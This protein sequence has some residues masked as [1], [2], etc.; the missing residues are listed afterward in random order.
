MHLPSMPFRFV[1]MCIV[2]QYRDRAGAQSKSR[3]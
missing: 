2:Q 1:W 3:T